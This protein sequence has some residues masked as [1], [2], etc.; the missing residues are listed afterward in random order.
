[1]QTTASGQFYVSPFLTFDSRSLTVIFQVRDT[2]SGDVTQQFPAESVVERY[3]RDPSARPFVLPEPAPAGDDQA[4][5]EPSGPPAPTI[6][7]PVTQA[8]RDAEASASDNTQTEA[9]SADGAASSITGTPSQ[10]PAGRV[11]IDLVA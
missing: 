2:E 3:R 7:G 11:S 4:I 8:I 10:P 9:T 6:G 5:E 1:M